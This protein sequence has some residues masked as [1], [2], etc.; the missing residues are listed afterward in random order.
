RDL[1]GF[2]DRCCWKE[3]E[4][5]LLVFLHFVGL[6]E[7]LLVQALPTKK[8]ACSRRALRRGRTF[9]ITPRLF[10]WSRTPRTPRGRR[11]NRIAACRPSCSSRRTRSAFS[12]IA[13]ARVSDSPWSRSRRKT[14][15]NDWLR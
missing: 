1:N 12:S 4:A 10:A 11:P 3:G 7:D 8:P 15:T 2:Q 5:T 13:R 6:L 9:P 14:V